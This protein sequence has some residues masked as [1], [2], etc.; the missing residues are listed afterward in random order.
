MCSSNNGDP[1]HAC[2]DGHLLFILMPLE[3][4]IESNS[5]FHALNRTCLTLLRE[6][7]QI[8]RC[9][10]ACIIFCMMIE[11]GRMVPNICGSAGWG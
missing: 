5:F 9:V 2:L 3:H 11:F 7:S 1:A 10:L 8:I 6:L 4:P